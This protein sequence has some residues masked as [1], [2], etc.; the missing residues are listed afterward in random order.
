MKK[1]IL[2]LLLIPFMANS[3][4]IFQKEISYNFAFSIIDIVQLPDDGYLACGS[5]KTST[6]D[7]TY[8]V[9][10]RFDSL[11]NV[12]WCKRYTI[13]ARDYFRCIEPTNDGNFLIGGTSKQDFS[14]FYGGTLFKID[15]MGNVIWHKLYFK[16]YDDVTLGV[17]E[18]SDN[19]LALIVRY[20]VTGQPSKVIKTDASGNLLHEYN[21]STTNVTSGVVA[22]CVTGNESGEYFIGGTALN[23][24]TSKYMHYV[25]CV[26]DNGLIWY[27]EYDF[28]RDK[29]YLY[30]IGML[31]DGNIGIAGRVADAANPDIYNG[32]AMKIDKV[33]GEAIWSKDI[34]LEGDYYQLV[35]GIYSLTNNEIIVSGRTDTDYGYQGFASKLDEDGNILWTR[36]YGEG[37]YEGLGYTFEVSGNRLFFTGYMAL[38]QGPY[39]VQTDANGFSAC[40]TNTLN[41]IA[42]DMSVTT[43]SPQTII[44]DPD[45]EVLSPAFS[46]AP[47]NLNETII[48]SGIVEVGETPVSTKFNVYPNPTKEYIIVE[49]INGSNAC[50]QIDIHNIEGELVYNSIMCKQKKVVITTFRPGVYFI[51]FR[52][53]ETSVTSRQKLII[54]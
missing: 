27:K 41:F 8:A 53:N 1:I 38:N 33:T 2:V 5:A 40:L 29:A 17:F 15:D 51:T 37:E 9:I 23:S 24:N 12:Q 28:G 14:A 47:L 3:Q 13:L 48:C 18:Q 22:D 32:V 44:D 21:I 36:E 11:L 20:G 49:N 10:V 52:N 30:G 6:I 26:N 7:S 50:Q 19:T 39:F 45:V 54:Q 16:D 4:A 34:K 25:C 46:E 35:G 43:Y 31:G 42:S